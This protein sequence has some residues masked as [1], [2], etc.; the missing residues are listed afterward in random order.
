MRVV[1]SDK[2]LAA[3]GV[4]IKERKSET[5]E[6]VSIDQLLHMYTKEC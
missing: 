3:G 1:V 6:I 2:S 5:S 4:E